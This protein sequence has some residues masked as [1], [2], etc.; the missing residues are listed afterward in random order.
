MISAGWPW[1]FL[2]FL[3]EVIKTWEAFRP[4]ACSLETHW[5]DYRDVWH[6]EPLLWAEGRMA[7]FL[8]YRC[9]WDG[10]VCCSQEALFI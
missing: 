10:H 2:V 5:S 6:E 9:V 8:D 4:G 7:D 3:P 1:V